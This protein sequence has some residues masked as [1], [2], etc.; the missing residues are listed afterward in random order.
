MTYFQLWS[1]EKIS[2]CKHISNDTFNFNAQSTE[3]E[4]D[5]I[6]TPI[7]L[8]L[9]F[10][11]SP[12]T[13]KTFLSSCTLHLSL[14][15]PLL[16]RL[17]AQSPV[18]SGSTG[19]SSLPQRMISAAPDNQRTFCSNKRPAFSGLSHTMLPTAVWGGEIYIHKHIHAFRTMISYTF[20]RV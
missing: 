13:L 18:N 8:P 1:V 16:R 12:L 14:Y 11:Y 4:F 15:P 2:I 9:D 3:W 5:F 6:S 17:C 10:S 19:G 20:A 7:Y